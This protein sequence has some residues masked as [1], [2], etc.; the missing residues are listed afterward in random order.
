MREFLKDSQDHE[1]RARIK[2][3]TTEKAGFGSVGGLKRKCSTV[4]RFTGFGGGGRKRGNFN[5]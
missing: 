4:I 2:S 5:V 3:L 1:V